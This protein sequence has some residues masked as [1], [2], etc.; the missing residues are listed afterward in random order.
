VRHGKQN[1]NERAVMGEILYRFVEKINGEMGG[2]P[3]SFL[4][5]R[6]KITLKKISLR[7]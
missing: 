4:N 2:K 1:F 7:L 6:L 3:L 5:Y